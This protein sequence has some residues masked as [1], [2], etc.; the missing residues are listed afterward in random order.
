MDKVRW[1]K[2]LFL[3]LSMLIIVSAAAA[4]QSTVTS[5]PI[6]NEISMLEE[7]TFKLTI[8]NNAD[9]VQRYT[10]YALQSG[11]SWNVDPYP[12]KDKIIE[13]APGASQTTTIIADVLQE[14]P[15]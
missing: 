8:T 9:K 15:P 5:E 4:A 11:Q 10:I 3:F 1:M 2:G 6:K 13:L 12:L 14:L 7:A